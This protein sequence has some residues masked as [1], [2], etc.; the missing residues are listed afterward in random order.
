MVEVRQAFIAACVNATTHNGFDGCFID[1]AGYARGPPYPGANTK[2]QLNFAKKCNASIAAI[3]A[4]G[5]GTVSLLA[6]LQAAVGSS[7]LII[8]KDSF[9]GGSEKYVNSIF[10]MDTFCSCYRF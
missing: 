3:K 4:L 1:S 8:A 5:S 10:P 9:G 7:K 6:E 2:T